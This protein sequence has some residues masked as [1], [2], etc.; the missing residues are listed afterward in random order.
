MSEV[1]IP[2]VELNDGS[3]LPALGFGTWDLRGDAATQSVASAL[4]AGYRLIDSAVN[5]EN[6]REVGRAV[7]DRTDLADQSS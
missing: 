3:V 6:E 5:Y 4:D 7:A 2:S 1:T